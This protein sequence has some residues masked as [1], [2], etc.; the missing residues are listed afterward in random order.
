MIG[1]D[2]P[3]VW[4]LS[5]LP[6]LVYGLATGAA[7]QPDLRKVTVKVTYASGRGN[8]NAFETMTTLISRNAID[9]R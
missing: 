6:L 2:W 3:W 8:E 9:R 4:I 1:F 5:P 7:G